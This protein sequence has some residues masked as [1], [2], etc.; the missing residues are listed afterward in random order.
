MEGEFEEGEE[1]CSAMYRRRRSRPSGI[2]YE[3]G[4]QWEKNEDPFPVAT[5][6]PSNNEFRTGYAAVARQIQLREDLAR[7]SFLPSSLWFSPSPSLLFLLHFLFSVK[8]GSKEESQCIYDG[9]EDI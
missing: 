7:S 6:P 9:L 3:S 1:L 8:R 2:P 5:E 4:P